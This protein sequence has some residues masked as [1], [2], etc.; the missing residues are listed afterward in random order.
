MVYDYHFLAQTVSATSGAVDVKIW[1]LIVAHAVG[2]GGIAG[3]GKWS[4]PIDLVL[5]GARERA[6]GL[7]GTL[8]PLYKAII[9]WPAHFVRFMMLLLLVA[10]LFLTVFWSSRLSAASGSTSSSVV[11]ISIVTL[12]LSA[13]GGVAALTRMHHHLLHDALSKVPHWE[14]DAGIVSADWHLEELRRKP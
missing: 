2:T 13:I 5:A 9:V 3:V 4:G 14:F 1:G 12:V 8:P 7:G 6:R 10:N 11:I